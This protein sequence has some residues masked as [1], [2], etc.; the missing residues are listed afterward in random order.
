MNGGDLM[1]TQEACEIVE[2]LL[3]S[4]NKL[5]MKLLL[6]AAIHLGYK[7]PEEK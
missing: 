6:E 1:N 5:T 2:N 7:V 3:V 4:K